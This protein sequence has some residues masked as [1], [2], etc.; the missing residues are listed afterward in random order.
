MSSMII[1]QCSRRIFLWCAFLETLIIGGLASSL[2]DTWVGRGVGSLLMVCVIVGIVFVIA[3]LMQSPSRVIREL[4]AELL[5]SDD[6]PEVLT[7]VCRLSEMAGIPT[8]KV[9]ETNANHVATLSVGWST[10]RSVIV[11]NARALESLT[12]EERDSIP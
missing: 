7:S 3:V 4:Q 11:L 5:S 6:F 10:A 8:V 2:T 1:R 12:V 9:Y